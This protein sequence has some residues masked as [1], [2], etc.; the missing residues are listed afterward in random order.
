MNGD[1]SRAVDR[2]LRS[3][4]KSFIACFNSAVKASARETDIIII[5]VIIMATIIIIIAVSVTEYIYTDL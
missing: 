4:G 3:R 2:D 1:I 5:V